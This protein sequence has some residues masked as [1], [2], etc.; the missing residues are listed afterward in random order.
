MTKQSASGR[1]VASTLTTNLSAVNTASFPNVKMR[2][3]VPEDILL[4]YATDGREASVI[5]MLNASTVTLMVKKELSQE[6]EHFP[7]SKHCRTTR[8]RN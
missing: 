7:A 1:K 5:R 2:K 3:P 4:E 8:A 6:R